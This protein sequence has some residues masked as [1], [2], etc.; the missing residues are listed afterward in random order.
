MLKDGL[1]SNLVSG[2]VCTWVLKDDLSHHRRLDDRRKARLA[3]ALLAAASELAQVVLVSPWAFEQR[4]VEEEAGK[5][6]AAEA[7]R[8]E[9]VGVRVYT[10]TGPHASFERTLAGFLAWLHQD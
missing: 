9:E 1:V 3:E 4:R 2:F 6:R 5:T 7:T 8:R 10:E